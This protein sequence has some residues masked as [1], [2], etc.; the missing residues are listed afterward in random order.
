M[1]R[2]GILIDESVLKN[3]AV[4]LR[5]TIIRLEKEIYTPCRAGVQY[6]LPE[7]AGRHTLC[8]APSR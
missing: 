3:F 5:E 4:T 2:E 7:A 6:L 8:Q 1:E